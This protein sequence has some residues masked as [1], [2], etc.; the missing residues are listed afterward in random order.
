MVETSSEVSVNTSEN[1]HLEVK[2]L[3][4]TQIVSS[5][6]QNDHSEISLKL[7]E[8]SNKTNE[9]TVVVLKSYENL[10][11]IINGQKSCDVPIRK[12]AKQVGMHQ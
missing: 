12:K 11:C 4:D 2:Q 9:N 10:G 3:N 1:V 8:N 6:G 7:P 5:F